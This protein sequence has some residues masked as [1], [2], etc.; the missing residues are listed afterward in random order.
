M[1]GRTGSRPGSC[2]KPAQMA[3]PLKENLVPVQKVAKRR[4][5]PELRLIARK[6]IDFAKGT[7][8]GVDLES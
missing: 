8:V 5:C 4:T 2:N 7:D 6:T 1:D 3:V